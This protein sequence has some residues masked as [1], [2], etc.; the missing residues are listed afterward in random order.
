MKE[1]KVNKEKKMSFVYRIWMKMWDLKIRVVIVF[2]FVIYMELKWW[3][4][5][6]CVYRVIRNYL[7]C[8]VWI[9]IILWVENMIEYK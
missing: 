1:K 5:L 6:G 3:E 2:N 9:G 4:M 8:F 7:F